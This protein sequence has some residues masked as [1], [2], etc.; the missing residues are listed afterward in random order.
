MSARKGIA[1]PINISR[2]SSRSLFP[3]VTRHKTVSSTFSLRSIAI[4]LLLLIWVIV[5]HLPQL[6]KQSTFSGIAHFLI[7]FFIKGVYNN[8]G[9]T[10]RRH[11]I[12]NLI[13][14]SDL[15]ASVERVFF[16]T[17]KA[18]SHLVPKQ[19]FGNIALPSFIMY[20]S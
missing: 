4:S 13:S 18:Y 19:S 9:C 12:C 16:C 2:F 15:G 20:P 11:A 6:Y 8:A 1:L 10:P 7:A 5:S 3:C 14:Y 17:A